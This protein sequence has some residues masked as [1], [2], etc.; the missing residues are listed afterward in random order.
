VL[1][2]ARRIV[3]ALGL[4]LVALLLASPARAGDPGDGLPIVESGREAL[5]QGLAAPH[6]LQKELGPGWTFASIAISATTIRFVVKGPG[7]ATAT[8]RLEHPDRAPSKERT[9][10]FAL[11]REVHAE[12]GAEPPALTV[13]DPLVVAVSHNDTG[14]FWP[15]A[16]PIAPPGDRPADAGTGQGSLKVEEKSTR[17]ELT[18][19]RK[20]LLGGLG[21]ALLLLLVDRLRLRRR[22]KVG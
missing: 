5:I 22:S 21:A 16:R 6:L 12:G 9:A 11:H 4:A 19:K 18:L 1:A 15:A 10:S 7:A 2:V 3:V 14:H 17:W 13:L 20:L 8:L